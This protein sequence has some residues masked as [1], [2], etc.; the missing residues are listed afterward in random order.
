NVHFL[1]HEILNFYRYKYVIGKNSYSDKKKRI[2]SWTDR[3][4][5]YSKPNTPKPKQLYYGKYDSCLSDHRPVSSIF[6]IP[7]IEK[8]RKLPPIPPKL[9]EMKKR[10]TMQ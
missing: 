6:K 1:F 5:W 8:V 2:P 9:L 4:L 3:I 7:L 10:S